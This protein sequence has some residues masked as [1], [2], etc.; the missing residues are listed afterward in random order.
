MP[1]NA[2]YAT[3]A[4]QAVTAELARRRVFAR[5]ASV[6][7]APH[8]YR[9][10]EASLVVASDPRAL[11]HTFIVAVERT[12]WPPTMTIGTAGKDL[13]LILKGHWQAEC[14]GAGEIGCSWRVDRKSGQSK[15]AVMRRSR[16]H[17]AIT[18]HV[19]E[20]SCEITQAIFPR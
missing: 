7:S 13:G 16:A 1:V 18:Y 19:V 10:A 11:R 6:T 4:R 20:L 12:E 5:V 3:T 15:A 17:I 2:A 14:Q 9:D 8:D